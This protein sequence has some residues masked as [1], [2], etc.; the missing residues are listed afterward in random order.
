MNDAAHPHCFHCGE[1]IPGTLNIALPVNGHT[2]RFCCH[3]CKAV[4]ETILQEGLSGFYHHRSAPAITPKPLED[5]L[6]SQLRLYDHHRLQQSFVHCRPDGLPSAQLLI[7]GIT[8]AACIWLIEKHLG[9]QPGVVSINVNH[10]TQ[11]A[12]LVWDPQQTTLSNLLI[13]IA[14]LGYRARPFE[15]NTLEESLRAEQKRAIIRLCVAGMGALQGMMLAV[16]LYF[17][18]IHDVTPQFQVFFRW[19]SL[20]VATPVVFYSAQPFFRA[21]LRD[22]RFRHL[23]MDVPV[24]LAI[25]LAYG[26]SAWVTVAGGRHVYF[27]SVCMF[28]FFLSLGRFLEMRA[29]FRVG[30]ASASLEQVQPAIANRVSG[31]SLEPV[32]SF[33]LQPGDLVQVRP[34]ELIPADGEIVEGESSVSEAVLTGEFMP[35]RRRPGD[36]VSA[37]TLNG[38]GPLRFRVA[39][40]GPNTRLSAIMRILERAQS[41][42]PTTAV[43]ADRIAGHFVAIVLVTAALVYVGWAVA[44]NSDAFD[45]AL[46]VL[47]VTCPCALSLATPTALTAATAALRRIGFLPVRGNVLEGLADIDRVVFD[48]TGTLT[49]GRLS[50]LHTQPLSTRSTADCIAIATAL[51]AFSEH[52]IARAFREYGQTS[53]P[54]GAREVRNHIGRGLSGW[55]EDT[56]YILGSWDFVATRC[57]ANAPEKA[58]SGGILLFLATDDQWLARFE[59]NDQPRS[60]AR[61][62]LQRL[63]QLGVDSELLSGD[64][65]S[66][67]QTVSQ[68]LG[69]S[70][71]VGGA[72]PEAKLAHLQSLEQAGH[73]VAMVGDG[74]NDLPVMAGA[75]VSIAM[76]SAADLTQLQADA[77]LISNRLQ[78]LA[79]AVSLGRKTRRVIRQNL[80]WAIAYNLIALPLAIIGWVPPWIAAIGMSASSLIVVLNALRLGRSTDRDTPHGHSGA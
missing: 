66:Q 79:T 10:T 33:D 35:E 34:G 59:L 27:D 63:Q 73:R 75:R 16:P 46:S 15:P 48:K 80:G 36:W 20:L 23:T 12:T 47:V 52:P 69:L 30:L 6:V 14:E 32:A 60:D 7:E 5:S 53:L 65:S 61:T 28:T 67:V 9:K 24:S 42:K 4:C 41:E 44:G 18:V 72:S 25:A 43:V 26:A 3:G 1:P 40:A 8:C 37:G 54:I 56:H 62:T 38:D 76:A 21:A 71:F 13:A 55:I 19:L 17:G 39:Q 64:S 77:I 68:S 74:L 29:R 58:L 51:E 31:E 50:L 49:D 45:I 11:R 22:I 78:A 57:N 2:E 70:H